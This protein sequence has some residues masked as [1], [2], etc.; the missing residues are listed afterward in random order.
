[1]KR[2]GPD[3]ITITYDLLLWAIPIL[4]K[5]P[6]DQRFLLG[7]R[8]ESGLLDILEGLID[9]RYS[10]EKAELLRKANLGIEKQRFLFRLAKDL[11]YLSLRR[12]KFV[13]EKL[14]ETGRLVGG[15][16]KS[17]ERS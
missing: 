6:R 15:W 8:I 9:A 5:F 16:I 4:A 14:D 11:K 1:M 2:E 3:A 10:K 13:S 17:L 12:Y 7:D